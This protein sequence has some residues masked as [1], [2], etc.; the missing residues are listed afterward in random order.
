MSSITGNDLEKQQQ[1][2]TSRHDALVEV[3]G[4]MALA[5]LQRIRL[6]IVDEETTSD[7]DDQVHVFDEY[8]DGDEWN[9]I[10]NTSMVSSH[11]PNSRNTPS[12]SILAS[13]STSDTSYTFPENDEEQH[14]APITVPEPAY[15]PPQASDSTQTIAPT[16]NSRR[17]RKPPL[18]F[19]LGTLI[20]MHLL[21]P[22]VSLALVFGGLAG[23]CMCV[24]SVFLGETISEDD[25]AYL[26][27]AW[28]AYV[29]WPVRVVVSGQRRRALPIKAR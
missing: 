11:I 5:H 15:I 3:L 12:R 1:Q 29:L 4:A 19:K 7:N 10:D 26:W 13:I 21:S 16:P 24:Y 9:I 14:L 28:A 25:T 27:R 20:L 23:A 17:A 22:M 2:P 18:N 8:D 6:Y